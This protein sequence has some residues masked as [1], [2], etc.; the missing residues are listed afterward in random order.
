MIFDKPT[1]IFVYN[2]SGG[3]RTWLGAHRVGPLTDPIP[4]NDQWTWIDGSA[5]G[6]SNWSENQPD[7]HHGIEFCLEMDQ[8][9]Y[10]TWNDLPCNSA[11]NNHYYI[12]Q[13]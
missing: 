3:N 7:N 10:A 12:C 13:K 2:L 5:M 11:Y 8:W 4:R 6:F 1:N 9:R